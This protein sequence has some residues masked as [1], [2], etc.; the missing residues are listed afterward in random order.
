MG[1]FTLAS[2]MLLVIVHRSSPCVGIV[3]NFIMQRLNA[4]FQ[5]GGREGIVL[6]VASL[7]KGRQNGPSHA[8]LLAVLLVPR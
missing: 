7:H 2:A 3:I 5:G 8:F 4:R 6:S 1:V